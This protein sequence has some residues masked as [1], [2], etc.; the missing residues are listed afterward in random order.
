MLDS[1]S[2]T[3]TA[4]VLA[5]ERAEGDPL[6]RDAKVPHKSLLEVRG[7]PML[8][9]VV[10]CL[11]AVPSVD[12]V[13][14]SSGSA[15]LLDAHPELSRLRAAG[16]LEHRESAGSPA[17]SVELVLSRENSPR[18]MLVTTS[19]HPLLTPDMVEH[20]CSEAER[21]GAEVAA[22]VVSDAVFRARFPDARRTFIP[23]RGE[24]VTGAN[25]FWFRSGQ[26]AAAARFWK[27]TETFRKKPWRLAGLLGPG[28]WGLFLLRRIDLE[29]AALRISN[30]VGMSV[31]AIRLPYPEAGLDVDKPDDLILAERVLCE[32]DA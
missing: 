25:L 3:L 32:L 17:S 14:V 1:P 2:K 16:T 29:G 28:T 15:D 20:F 30:A 26:G 7:V 27:Q 12:R 22:A 31:A 24:G 21:S 13:L 9:R 8:V 18:P 10:G 19:D 11:A 23:L 4:L 5:G 6:A